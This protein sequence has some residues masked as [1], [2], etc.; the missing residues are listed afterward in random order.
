MS[1]A[2][3]IVII[4]GGFCGTITAVNLMRNT[5]APLKITIVNSGAPFIRGVAYSAYS[6]QHL[7][8][9]V[10]GNM[11]AFPDD[12]LHFINWLLAH[13]TYKHYD[14][15]L[16]ENTFIPRN[17]Y[18]DYLC[19]IWNAAIVKKKQDAEVNVIEDFVND[20]KF[21]N[22]HTVKV[23]LKKLSLY[24]PTMWCW[25]Q[26]TLCRVILLLQIWITI[27]TPPIFAIPGM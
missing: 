23:I 4:G 21:E 11:S 7:L 26:V 1:G 8:N 27:P 15:S 9:V 14:K 17:I 13:D 24:W 3:H 19:D 2:K 20:L 25:Q 12:N 10:A 22:T 5:D 18:G 16:L 6:Q